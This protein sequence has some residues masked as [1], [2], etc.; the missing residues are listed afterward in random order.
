MAPGSKYQRSP[1]PARRPASTLPDR[2]RLREGWLHAGAVVVAD[3]VK[4]PEYHAFMRAKEGALVRTREHSTYVEYQTVIKDIVLE[5]DF[6][7]DPTKL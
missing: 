5:S 3:N 2:S 1:R 6:L 4:R 7:G